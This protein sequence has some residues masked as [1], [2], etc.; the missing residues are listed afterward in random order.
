MRDAWGWILNPF[1]TATNVSIRAERIRRRGFGELDLLKVPG[2]GAT[3]VVFE[4]LLP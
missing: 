4:P 1:W 2:I 3:P